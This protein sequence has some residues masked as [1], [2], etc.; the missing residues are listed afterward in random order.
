MLVR[1]RLFLAMIKRSEPVSEAL[2]AIAGVAVY[3]LFPYFD[4]V[5]PTVVGPAL[6][7]S[8]PDHANTH[9]SALCAHLHNALQCF[10]QLAIFGVLLKLFD[11][12]RC[13][14]DPAGC[15][16]RF[17]EYKWEVS[18]RRAIAT[19]T[20]GTNDTQ[21]IH[22]EHRNIFSTLDAMS[23]CDVIILVLCLQMYVAM[24]DHL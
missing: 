3:L 10:A 11:I 5:P 6:L 12:G 8:V 20:N 2:A 7:R 19:A 14:I 9:A 15:S 4:A 24:H 17:D 22:E 1:E 13:K 18:V 16:K 23:S 21:G